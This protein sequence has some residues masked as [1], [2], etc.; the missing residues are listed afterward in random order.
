MFGKTKEK[1]MC[2]F[3]LVSNILDIELISNNDQSKL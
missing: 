2:P 3:F 1:K